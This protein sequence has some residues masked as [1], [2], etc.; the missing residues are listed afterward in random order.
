MVKCVCVSFGSNDFM[1]KTQP[2]P[3]DGHN[4]TDIFNSMGHPRSNSVVSLVL[5]TIAVQWLGHQYCITSH[6]G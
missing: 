1:T 4:K 5:C 6:S 3:M 2:F